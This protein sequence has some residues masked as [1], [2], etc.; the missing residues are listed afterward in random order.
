MEDTKNVI[1][2]Y[3]NCDEES[4]MSQNPLEYIRCKEII[5]RFLTKN[6]MSILDIGGATGAFSFWLAEQGHDVSLIDF[7][8]KHIDIARK[9]EQE[10]GIKLASIILG[11]ARELPYK[12][13]SFDLVLIMGP[14]YHL[15]ESP[16]RLKSLREAYRVLL[17]QGKVICEFISRFASM[18]DGFQS[19]LINDPDFIEIMHRDIKT[20]IHRDTSKAKNYFTNAYFHHADEISCEIEESGFIFEELIAVTSFGWMLPDIGNKIK[21]NNYRSVLLDT[22]KLVEKEKSLM[23]ISS[24]CIGIGKKGR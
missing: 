19:G 20:G 1:K 6:N 10:K 11:D 9:H 15:T 13:N 4:R 23:G 18:I 21:D 12:D 24:H 16:E 22:I 5:S 3:Q 8:P 17:P 14:L 7:V 2:Y